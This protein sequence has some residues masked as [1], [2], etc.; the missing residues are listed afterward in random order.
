MHDDDEMDEEPLH[1]EDSSDQKFLAKPKSRKKFAKAVDE[2][3]KVQGE[4]ELYTEEFLNK[5]LNIDAKQENGKM[6]QEGLDLEKTPMSTIRFEDPSIGL[7]PVLLKSL[8]KM[9]DHTHFTKIQYNLLG[10]I[11]QHN[12][13]LIRSTTGSGKTLAYLIPI[14]HTLLRLKLGDDMISEDAIGRTPTVGAFQNRT[15]GVQAI[16]VVPTRELALQIYQI[17]CALS[18][19]CISIVP[20][21]L[22]GGENIQKEK[23]RLRKGIN[24]LIGTPSKLAYHL[25]SSVKNCSLLSLKWLVV[26]ECDLSFGLGQGKY[27]REVLDIVK[28]YELNSG[29]GVKQGFGS[30]KERPKKGD[31]KKLAE[32]Q[33]KLNEVSTAG[34]SIQT[35]QLAVEVEDSETAGKDPQNIKEME[36]K[37]K[38]AIRGGYE[39]KGYDPESGQFVGSNAPQRHQSKR[40]WK[41]EREMAI[42]TGEPVGNSLNVAGG[43]FFADDRAGFIKGGISQS[44]TNQSQVLDLDDDSSLQIKP[45]SKPK[46]TNQVVRQEKQ[47]QYQ[48][49]YGITKLFTTASY[50]NVVRE[51]MESLVSKDDVK[52]IGS[53]DFEKEHGYSNYSDITV[54]EKLKQNYVILQE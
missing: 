35:Q 23:A 29:R 3:Y 21:L 45:L 12:N 13:C 43:G 16:V 25:R 2:G 7:H 22:V 44:L 6:A 54:P 20:G 18:Q 8:L 26:E 40:D 50:S 36:K 51:A 34:S 37:I 30:F 33:A 24:I 53:Y 31:L 15:S 48:I 42:E 38:D 28:D 5:F 4:A 9:K 41:A 49:E 11:L 19:S 27:L 52:Y 1:K 47:D 14:Y 39:Y 46:E 32:K 17:C 10:H